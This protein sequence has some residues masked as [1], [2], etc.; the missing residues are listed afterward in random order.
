MATQTLPTSNAYITTSVP[1]TERPSL[2]Y[3]RPKQNHSKKSTKNSI[4]GI[5][6]IYMGW[7]AHKETHLIIIIIVV[8]ITSSRSEKR[9]KVFHTQAYILASAQRSS[10]QG[11]LLVLQLK[12]KQYLHTSRNQ[13][14]VENTYEENSVFHGVVNLELEYIHIACLSETMRSVE[15]LILKKE[16]EVSSKSQGTKSMCFRVPQVRGSTTYPPR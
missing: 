11:S 9:K 6:T 16:R 13:R 1:C 3:I 14:K 15:S 12:T 5:F 4:A 10:S 2:E 7:I 8:I